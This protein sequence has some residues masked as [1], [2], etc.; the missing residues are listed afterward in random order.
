MMKG[1]AKKPA[2]GSAFDMSV[3]QGTLKISLVDFGGGVEEGHQGRARLDAHGHR[4]GD[5]V[6]PVVNRA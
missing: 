3:D 4:F 5:A 2:K 1:K 6:A